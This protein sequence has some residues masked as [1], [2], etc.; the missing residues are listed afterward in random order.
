VGLW[1]ER[2]A[3]GSGRELAGVDGVETLYRSG[4]WEF[5][6]VLGDFSR[7]MKD[8]VERVAARL[9]APAI[10]FYVADSDAAAIYFAGP[11]SAAGWLA[12]NQSYDDSDEAHTQ[13]WLDPEEHRN[14]AAEL[15]AWAVAYAPRKPTEAEIVAALAAH[16]DTG[17]S[18]SIGGRAMVFAE[19][20]VEAVFNELLGIGS[21]HADTGD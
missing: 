9:E 4:D 14:A 6:N 12:I 2:V 11:G 18:E 13:Q 1:A 21:I 7:P 17:L 16:E 19:E 15:A 10:G 20:G 5:G 3:V 8:V